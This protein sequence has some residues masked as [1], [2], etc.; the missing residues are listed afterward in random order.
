MN[1]KAPSLGP[2]KSLLV[3]R[4]V[5][6]TGD[7]V[8]IPNPHE[9]LQF[10]IGDD[11]SASDPFVSLNSQRTNT[12][13]SSSVQEQAA[14]FRSQALI[15][16]VAQV[17]SR[18]TPS[19]NILQAA[20]IAPPGFIDSTV[21][22]D[23]SSQVQQTVPTPSQH[24]VPAPKKK[25]QSKK[26]TN[27][28]KIKAGHPS[29]GAQ[30]QSQQGSLQA[31]KNLLN[32]PPS[33]PTSPQA[34]S[35]GGDQGNSAQNP[36]HQTTGGNTGNPNTSNPNLG[37]VTGGNT[38]YPNSNSNLPNSG[39][40][41]QA[42]QNQGPSTFAHPSHGQGPVNQNL[43]N[44]GNNSSSADAMASLVAQVA[45]LIGDMR[46]GAGLLNQRPRDQEVLMRSDQLE[47]AASKNSFDYRLNGFSTKS[48]YDHLLERGM[49]G[50]VG[51]KQS[52]AHQILYRTLK[53]IVIT[54]IINTPLATMTGLILPNCIEFSQPVLAAI[55]VARQLLKHPTAD[56][57]STKEY[58][59][60]YLLSE[61]SGELSTA[62]AKDD[63]AISTLWA[64]AAGTAKGLVSGFGN[65][66]EAI[67]LMVINNATAKELSRF[68]FNVD[69]TKID[70]ENKLI[71][72][73]GV[74]KALMRG[75][76][77]TIDSLTLSISP[78]KEVL[79][80]ALGQT[81][82]AKLDID[83]LET[84][85]SKLAKG[86]KTFLLTANTLIIPH[87]GWTFDV[88]MAKFALLAVDLPT[89]A[90]AIFAEFF[91][92][93]NDAISRIIPDIS[94]AIWDYF[95]FRWMEDV[96]TC[97]KMFMYAFRITDCVS[98]GS[99]SP[100]AAQAI[101]VETLDRADNLR[102]RH[103]GAPTCPFKWWAKHAHRL[104]E[105]PKHKPKQNGNGRAMS[106]IS[107]EILLQAGQIPNDT[108]NRVPSPEGA[109]QR[110]SSS[111]INSSNNNKKKK[112]ASN[113]KVNKAESSKK[114]RAANDLNNSANSSS[115]SAPK[116]QKVDKKNSNGLDK[117]RKALLG[118]LE[119][120]TPEARAKVENVVKLVPVKDA[121]EG[122]D[123]F[124]VKVDPDT[125]TFSLTKSR[126]HQHK[127]G[128]CTQKV[129]SEKTLEELL[130]A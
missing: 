110:G 120:L 52:E 83:G 111:N 39:S 20:D 63:T 61:P 126:C 40:P 59:A 37:G 121:K 50:T 106:H 69:E 112:G 127:S 81:A 72:I 86:A 58:T 15:D 99:L 92:L 128:K 21:N 87:A 124:S 100:S 62:E 64:E 1:Q 32:G 122:E 9:I 25:S 93:T 5:Q 129:H 30:S 42:N 60:A 14:A 88:S 44:N 57:S 89:F 19:S 54:Q 12:A 51:G 118:L 115:G 113:K 82:V 34:D 26:A 16:Q 73:P 117:A 104:T 2:S 116:K 45:S 119:P 67:C 28:T 29:S 74:D 46:Q 97:L 48:D 43:V 6:D 94:L 36:P 3:T 56:G 33:G 7:S 71:L 98:N 125:C 109:N 90:T 77:A 78:T 79:T 65:M 107:P 130:K 41:N 75:S 68:L 31:G 114:K 66:V 24:T 91:N 80:Q 11:P 13:P 70:P 123:K 18:R 84:R 22:A 17:E 38:G 10:N 103:V 101:Y 4:E 23:P 27:D 53:R 102:K 47:Q 96:L 108:T 49:V 85:A 35:G 8:N 55:G 95:G 105:D 76:L